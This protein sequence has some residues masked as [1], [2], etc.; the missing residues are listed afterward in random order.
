MVMTIVMTMVMMLVM[1]VVMMMAVVMMMMLSTTMLS[2]MLMVMMTLLLMMMTFKIMMT[3]GIARGSTGG[4]CKRKVGRVHGRTLK[5]RILRKEADR[6]HLVT[7][8]LAFALACFETV[9]HVRYPEI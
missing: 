1:T 2:M 8:L 9:R 4:S 6:W 3:V 7:D 5:L